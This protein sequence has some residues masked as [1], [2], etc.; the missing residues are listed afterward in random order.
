M[1]PNVSRTR[2]FRVS[3]LTLDTAVFCTS[4][5]KAADTSDEEEVSEKLFQQCTSMCLV[6]VLFLAKH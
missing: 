6:L 5:K 3:A 4:V 1:T 2:Q